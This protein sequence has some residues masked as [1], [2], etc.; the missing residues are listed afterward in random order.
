MIACL[1]IYLV[2]V[3]REWFPRVPVAYFGVVG[4]Q[5]NFAPSESLFLSVPR[6]VSR[7]FAGVEIHLS[8]AEYNLRKVHLPVCLQSIVPLALLLL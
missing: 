1:V 5:E 3:G 6:N 7:L 4:E 8:I 2:L